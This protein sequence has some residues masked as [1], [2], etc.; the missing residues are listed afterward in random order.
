MDSMSKV[1]K[2]SR[3]TAF[4]S[5]RPCLVTRVATAK[6]A[7][8]RFLGLTKSQV[9]DYLY[10]AHAHF[11]L[12]AIVMLIPFFGWGFHRL[13]TKV[14]PQKRRELEKQEEEFLKE[15]RYQG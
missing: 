7:P 14:L 2:P 12:Y 1:P 4:L 8:P 3:T 10:R 6:R 11:H 5:V 15:G 9:L 13:T